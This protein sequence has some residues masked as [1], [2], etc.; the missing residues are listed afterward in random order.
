M[1]YLNEDEGQFDDYTPELCDTNLIDRLFNYFKQIETGEINAGIKTKQGIARFKKMYEK[2]QQED[3]YY[4]F[5]EDILIDYWYFAYE[6]RHYEGVLEGQRVELTDFQLFQ[7]AGILCFIKYENDARLVRKVYIQIGR[8]NAKS[9][10]EGILG[11]YVAFIGEER[12]RIFIAGWGREQSDEV[13]SAIKLGIEHSELLKGK[14]KETY[15]K[16]TV[17]NNNSVI[18]P[19]SKE[20]RKTGDGKNISVGILD[21]YHVHETSEIYD[22]LESGTGARREPLIII[23]TTAGFNLSAPCVDVYGYCARL[24]DPADDLENDEYFAL[25]YE[26]DKGDDIKDESNW[27]KSNPIVCTYPEGFDGIRSA[28]KTA[29]EI[30]SEMRNFLTKRMNMWV[31]MAEDGYLDLAKWNRQE[32]SKEE[33]D[34]I[35]DNG[36]VYIGVDLA[37]TT[38]LTSVALVGVNGGKFA[39]RQHSFVPSEKFRERMNRDKVRYDVF[40]DEGYMT[41]TEGDVVDYDVI[42]N[43]IADLCN[44]YDVK[45]IL[46]DPW[47]ATHLVTQLT[48]EGYPMIEMPQRITTLSD[49]TKQFRAKVY[50][51]KIIHEGDGLLKW[52]VSN[53]VTRS[54][55]NENVILDKAKARD[56]IDPIAAAINGFARCMHDDLVHNLN[57]YFMSDGFSF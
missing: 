45:E 19:L 12:Q 14:W 36:S 48:N 44:Q 5:N 54:D 15:G 47:N 28:L 1:S 57:D 23:I 32:V 42:K 20:A 21:E 10:T 6:F 49:P 50:E 39:I 52:A 4:Y 26:M 25:I 13:Y 33:V 37:A 30:P 27:I 3:N 2:S 38:D 24:L 34:D 16:I 43:H 7:A 18:I 53:A 9:Q 55:A 46:Y 56:R 41:L 31:D 8:K 40:R 17:K 29:L 11:A 35:L 51:G 22:V